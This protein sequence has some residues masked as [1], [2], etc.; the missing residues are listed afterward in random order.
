[1][2]N[3]KVWFIKIAC[4]KAD[5]YDWLRLGDFLANILIIN[6]QSPMAQHSVTSCL[7]KRNVARYVFVVLFLENE[8]K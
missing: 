2:N 4:T 1:M 6:W 3:H 8:T 5:A 7:K